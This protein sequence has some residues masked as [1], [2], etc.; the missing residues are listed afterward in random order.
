[1]VGRETIRRTTT[2][3]K[4]EEEGQNSAACTVR[5]CVLEMEKAGHKGR[6][7]VCM[8]ESGHCS[9]K[10]DPNPGHPEYVYATALRRNNDFATNA[11]AVHCCVSV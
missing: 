4:S 1:M 10:S 3:S 11:K 6:Q 8:S 2:L 7:G 9:R 5:A